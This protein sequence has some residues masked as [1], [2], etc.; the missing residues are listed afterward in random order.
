MRDRMI[1][2]LGALL[3]LAACDASHPDAPPVLAV[4]DS[5]RIQ[6]SESLYVG[7]PNAVAVSP[8]G[9]VF[10]SDF[11]ERTILRASRAGDNLT[12]VAARGG[13]PGEV[14]SP[15]SL[16]ILGDTLLAVQN[17]GGKRIE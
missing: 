13:G 5:V 12:L 1:T 3:F 7:R 16:A 4:I 2:I 14:S 8:N 6:E 15:T 11:A 10:I 9:S 17:A